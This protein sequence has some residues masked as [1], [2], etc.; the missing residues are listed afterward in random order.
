MESVA[1]SVISMRDIVRFLFKWWRSITFITMFVVTV[2]SVLAYYAPQ[3]YKAK[4][5]VLI[6]GVQAILTDQS[7]LP[8]VDMDVALN[9]EAEIVIS[10][11]VLDA[12]VNN[13]ELHLLPKSDTFVQRVKDFVEHNLAALGLITLT[14]ETENWI[15][16]LEDSIKVKTV[17]RSNVLEVALTLESAQMAAD[18]INELTQAYVKHH[19]A[20]YTASDENVF[21][22]EQVSRIEEQMRGRNQELEQFRLRDPKSSSPEAKASISQSLSELRGKESSLVSRIIDLHINYTED[23]PKVLAENNKLNAIRGNI[24]ETEKAL[25]ETE[26]RE[27]QK[28]MIE[29]NLSSLRATHK[30]FV[31]LRENA[32][33]TQ[34]ATSG[35]TNVRIIE[36]AAI[37][38]RPTSSRLFIIA[39]ALAG[40]LTLAICIAMV[41]EYFDQRVERA[42]IAEQILGKPVVGLIPEYRVRG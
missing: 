33:M 9:T 2:A 7:V 36:R 6:E 38:A 32:K 5:R 4:S 15:R 20:V 22:G 37:P 11:P 28:A 30:R 26:R 42:D 34:L 3:S 27:E 40:G 17:P 29:S 41:R 24:K 12:V 18:V 14:S 16:F 35:T 10:R 1:N 39:I 13:L 8:G 23:H 25:L 31:E 19:L 21:Y